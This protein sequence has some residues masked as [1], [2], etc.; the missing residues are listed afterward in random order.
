[1]S[2][3]L[4][5]SQVT[6]LFSDSL[7][8]YPY[9]LGLVYLVSALG[10]PLFGLMIDKTGKNVSWVLVSLI[11]SLVAHGLINFTYLT[12]YLPI[13]MMGMSYSI[14]SSALWSLPALLIPERQLG[15][16]FGI[17]QVLRKMHQHWAGDFM[18]G[19]QMAGDFWPGAHLSG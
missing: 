1:M 4:I 5:S 13:I 3:R 18:A 10:S 7:F 8:T 19:Y 16:A 14:L 15:T 6:F 11:G 2:Q 17:M 12:P 9:N